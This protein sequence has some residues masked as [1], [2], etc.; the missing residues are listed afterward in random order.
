[1]NEWLAGKKPEGR[2]AEE[3]SKLPDAA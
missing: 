3:E 2:K 1:L